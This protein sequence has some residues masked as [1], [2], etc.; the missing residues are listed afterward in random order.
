MEEPARGR[1]LPEKPT[2]EDVTALRGVAIDVDP[3]AAEE[4]QPGGFDRE[5]KRLMDLAGA[6][7]RGDDVPS[8]AAVIDSGNGMQAI[9]LF[10]EPLP[11]TPENRTKVEA[12]GRALAR[13]YGGD[14]VHSIEHLFRVP[15]TA[16]FPNAK[17]REKGRVRTQAA[18]LRF[19]PKRRAL[20]ASI[21]AAVSKELAALT[22]QVSAGSLAD[23]DFARVIAAAE[24]AEDGSDSPDSD[25]ASIVARV[26]ER[27]AVRGI[28]ENTDCSARDF[29]LACQCVQAGISDPT[30]IGAVTFALS[31]ER[32]LEDEQAGRGEYYAQRTVARAMAKA[33]RE[34][35]PE[36]FFEVI[37]GADRVPTSAR[38]VP[39]RGVFTLHRIGDI[40]IKEPEFL[41]RGL[42]ETDSLVLLFGDPE[43][44]KSFVAL[45]IAASVATG[46]AF[47]GRPVKPG[48]VIYIAGEGRNGIKRRL[49]AW[50]ALNGEC[51]DAAPLFVSGA[52]ANMVEPD[53]WADVS[54]AV[55]ALAE[56]EGPPALIVLD[57]LAR[58][59]GPGDENAT[60]DMNRFVAAVDALRAE[61]GDCV[62]LIVHHSGHSDKARA[63]GSTAL[64]AAL[65]AEYRVEKAE[66]VVTLTNTKMKEAA[67]PARIAFELRPVVVGVGQNA[68]PIQSAALME[69]QR[70][71]ERGPKPSAN[72]RI[73]LRAFEEARDKVGGSAT[74]NSPVNIDAWRDEFYRC[75]T[76]NSQDAKRRA[77]GR[78]RESLTEKGLLAVDHD[79]Y[80]E[81]AITW[82]GE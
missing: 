60:A 70:P 13:R 65:D 8:P 45:D 49:A 62:V 17:K 42:V 30:E 3:D 79:F 24:A 38:Q 19:D 69:T 25:L 80:S 35:L 75:H 9:W 33:Q 61:A 50:A 5:R 53:A 23:F 47:H 14:A 56:A 36:A 11:V 16:N 44:G 22:P 58:N 73:A 67:P 7:W 10:P 37:A 43:A 71:V 72:E 57:T 29:A 4:A 76:G 68:E 63:R 34:S 59:F 27:P 64:R 39:R 2:A 48:P 32:L 20:L 77:F 82:P 26:R 55:R 51:L 81:G 1:G 54:A 31:P 66:N 78:A 74:A 12:L 52:S 15:G 28:L 40:A 46:R 21:E 6:L 41:V 18:L